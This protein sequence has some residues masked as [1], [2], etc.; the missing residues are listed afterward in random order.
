[1]SENV[2]ERAREALAKVEGMHREDWCICM[3]AT[4]PAEVE[5]ALRDVIGQLE[6][7]RQLADD[8]VK[9]DMTPTMMFTDAS[10]MYTQWQAYVARIDAAW[11]GAVTQAAAGNV[12]VGSD[13]AD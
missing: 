8:G 5:S 1:M 3:S 11:R 7:V 6:Q 12:E 9:F 10:A 13:A 2:I 4:I